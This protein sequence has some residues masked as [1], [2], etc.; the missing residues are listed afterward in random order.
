MRGKEWVGK[1][2]KYY[3]YQ[4][5]PEKNV[6]HDAENIKTPY[7]PYTYPRRARDRLDSLSF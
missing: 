3:S 1:S 7:N 2:E 6:N 5:M 4:K